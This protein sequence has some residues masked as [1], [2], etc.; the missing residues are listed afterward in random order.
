MFNPGNFGTE[1]NNMTPGELKL[2]DY[3]FGSRPSALSF[4]YHYDVVKAGNG[5]FG[6]VEIEVLDQDGQTIAS[7]NANITE[8]ESDKLGQ[9]QEM[10]LNL[11]Y[12]IHS[13]KASKISIK[14]VSSVNPAA[15]KK[16]KDFWNLPGYNNL[17]GGEYVGS[18]L[19][20]DD[21]TLI[22]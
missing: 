9:Y 17:S 8:P 12:D 4:Y 11:K 7:G 22:Y 6:T 13:Q 19:Y 20:V 5:D 1:V 10:R 15:L 16:D 3:T 18:E 2:E 14:F 21:I